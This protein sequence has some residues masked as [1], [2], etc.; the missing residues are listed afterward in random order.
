M[1]EKYEKVGERIR[2]RLVIR[3]YVKAGGQLDVERFGWDYRLS[4]TNLYNWLADKYLPFKDLRKLCEGLACSSDWLLFGVEH[5]PKAPPAKGRQ[6][7]LKNLLLALTA[8]S[9]ALLSPS[10][11]GAADLTPNAWSDNPSYRKLRRELGLAAA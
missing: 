10:G 5:Y 3:G 4:K 9:A 1:A 6:G 8:A 11:G 2:E 7:K